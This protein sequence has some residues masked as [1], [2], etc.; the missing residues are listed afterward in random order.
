MTKADLVDQI[1]EGT[2]LTKIETKAV[3]EGFMAA[4]S[5]AMREGKRIELRGFGSF[6]VKHRAARTARNPQTNE[7]V[8]VEA[9]YVPVFNV[10]DGLQ[11][12][13]DQAMK[14]RD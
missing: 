3:V 7:P 13:V 5:Q 11:E 4:V 6:E 2:G 9:R 14:D 1:A 8:Q 10:S 12:E